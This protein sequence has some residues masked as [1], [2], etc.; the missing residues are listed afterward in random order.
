LKDPSKRRE[1]EEMLPWSSGLLDMTL[2]SELLHMANGGIF[3]A[4]MFFFLPAKTMVD[5][6]NG[7]NVWVPK[8]DASPDDEPEVRGAFGVRFHTP[9]QACIFNAAL[10]TAC[11]L[12]RIFWRWTLRQKYLVQ[13]RLWGD[14]FAVRGPRRR[15]HLHFSR[16]HSAES[17]PSLAQRAASSA[18]TCRQRRG[19][20]SARLRDGPRRRTACARRAVLSAR[21]PRLYAGHGVLPLLRAARAARGAPPPTSQVTRRYPHNLTGSGR[22]TSRRGPPAAGTP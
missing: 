11:P 2:D 12:V 10:L 14:V 1:K 21:A 18:C 20:L 7:D 3:G 22:V 4:W 19:L 16:I 15:F 8:Q 6:E 9:G 13:G 17:R 5:V